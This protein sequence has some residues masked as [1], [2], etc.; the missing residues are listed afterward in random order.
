MVPQ[1]NPLVMKVRLQNEARIKWSPFDS[2]HKDKRKLV[3]LT[4]CL[5]RQDDV[6]D[7]TRNGVSGDDACGHLHVIG[8]QRVAKD[9]K[10]SAIDITPALCGLSHSIFAENLI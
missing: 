8:A 9:A 3:A 4:A 6:R 1:L 10:C 7:A 2:T 5:R